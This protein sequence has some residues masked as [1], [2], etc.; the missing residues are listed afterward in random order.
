MSHLQESKVSH[1]TREHD[2]RDSDLRLMRMPDVTVR[3]AEWGREYPILLTLQGRTGALS[4]ALREFGSMCLRAENYELA[5]EVF[6][7]SVSMKPDD[8][9]LWRN[10]SCAYQGAANQ[11][12]A[13]RSIR[14]ALDLDNSHAELWMQYGVLLRDM[15][16]A[17]P[18]EGA[19]ICTIALDSENIEARYALA[20]LLMDSGRFSE[21][22]DLFEVCLRAD[23]SDRLSRAKLEHARNMSG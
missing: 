15:G 19:F 20:S 13:L 4:T 21:A 11:T 10:L 8:C 18:A 2:I 5:A 22:A 7:A 6:L 12:L 1:R 14:R 16:Q 17:K 23:P 9:W 3:I